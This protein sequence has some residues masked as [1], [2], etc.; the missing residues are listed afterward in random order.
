MSLKARADTAGKLVGG[1]P[2]SFPSPPL[3]VATQTSMLPP[4][5]SQRMKP[6]T[7]LKSWRR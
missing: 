3:P 1:S 5:G 4:W 6:D 2:T 7:A